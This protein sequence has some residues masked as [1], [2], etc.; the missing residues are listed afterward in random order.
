MPSE[1]EMKWGCTFFSFDYRLKKILTSSWLR[2][3]RLYIINC[4]IFRRRMWLVRN[5][6]TYSKYVINSL[7]YLTDK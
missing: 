3:I 1:N 7:P 6:F 2:L 5:L 4:S